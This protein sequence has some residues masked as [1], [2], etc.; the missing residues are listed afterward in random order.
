MGVLLRRGQRDISHRASG[1]L[2]V[3]EGRRG[4]FLLVR[5]TVFTVDVCLDG[6]VALRLPCAKLRLL[7]WLLH[8]SLCI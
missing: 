4:G 2:N 8:T 3:L 7:G 5:V 6:R 1:G